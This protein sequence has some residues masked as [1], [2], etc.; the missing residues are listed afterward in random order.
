MNLNTEPEKLKIGDSV[1]TE[2]IYN[3]EKIVRIITSIRPSKDY[4]S[5]FVASAG[6]GGICPNCK[7]SYGAT[8]KPIDAAWFIP[9]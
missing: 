6:S 5:G 7:R 3:E 9:V 4:E 1:T 8:I 2:Y